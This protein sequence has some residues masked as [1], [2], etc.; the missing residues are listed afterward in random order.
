MWL[1]SG[2]PEDPEGEIVMKMQGANKLYSAVKRVMPAIKTEYLDTQQDAVGQMDQIAKPWMISR[3]LES[4]LATEK[5]L[6]RKP[7][8]NGNLV[9]L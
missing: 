6:V 1:F 5:P 7:K 8:V 9:H 2:V 4:K 3:W